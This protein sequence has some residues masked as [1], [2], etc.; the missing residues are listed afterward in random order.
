[1]ESWEELGNDCDIEGSVLYIAACARLGDTRRLRDCLE[2][3][4]DQDV[5]IRLTFQPLFLQY[6]VSK[7]LVKDEETWAESGSLPSFVQRAAQLARRGEEGGF[8]CRRHGALL[9]A[10]GQEKV[11]AEGFNHHA[12]P[13]GPRGPDPRNDGL[14]R[15]FSTVEEAPNTWLPQWI[16]RVSI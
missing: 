4:L 2:R 13:L 8:Y 11:L 16:S 14:M 3:L 1:M 12:S 9:L 5:D 7:G 10:K 15:T 6:L